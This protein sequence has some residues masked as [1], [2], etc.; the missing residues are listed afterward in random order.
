MTRREVLR[1]LTAAATAPVSGAA[2]PV[3]VL[4]LMADQFRDDALSCAGNPVVH[5]PNLDRLATEGVRFTDA[6]CA[7]PLCGPSRASLLTGQY[8]H[9]HGCYGNYEMD[10]PGMREDVRTWDERLAAHGYVV[11]YHGKWHVG[12]ANRSCYRGGLGD[13][14]ELYHE[15]LRERYPD[16]RKRPGEAVDRYSKWPYRPVAADRM[17]LESLKQKLVMPHHNEAGEHAAPAGDSLTA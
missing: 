7:A 6:V 4:F 12:S 3:N 16:R 8:A 17:M 2:A 1:S 9:G 5:T 11:E 14:L 15:Y 10:Q 13:Y